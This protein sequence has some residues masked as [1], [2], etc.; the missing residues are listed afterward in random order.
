MKTRPIK[1]IIGVDQTGAAIRNGTQAKPL[2]L[3]VGFRKKNTWSFLTEWKK[4]KITLSSMNPVEITQ[5]FD[6][7]GLPLI[8]EDTV[9]VLDCVLGLPR[10]VTKPLSQVDIWK[11]FS[12]ASQFK[13]PNGQFGRKSAEEFFKKIWSQKTNPIPKRTCEVWSKSNSVFQSRPYQK[14][15]QTG[16]FRLWKEL[17]HPKEPWAQIWPYDLA[18]SKS[19]IK[20]PWIFEGYPSLIW[21]KLL[22]CPH[23]DLRLL[24]QS[25]Y[26]RMEGIELDTWRT[27][28]N[29]P[30]HAD[31]FVLAWGAAYLESVHRLWVP[32]PGFQDEMKKLQEGWIMG[33]DSP[34]GI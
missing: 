31:A 30:D 21:K 34:K 12:Q 17:G 8:W 23:R 11:F 6:E 7:I 28:E 26:Q 18:Q 25:V 19:P 14:N 33:L 20:G 32:F 10:L 13:S 4:Q 2:P 24:K 1:T 29:R 5:L 15:I 22:L 16:T 27:V 9:L 3:V